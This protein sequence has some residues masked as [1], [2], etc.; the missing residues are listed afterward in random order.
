DSVRDRERD[1]G[2]DERDGRAERLEEVEA[3]PAAERFFEDRHE[4]GDREQIGGPRTEPGRIPELGDAL[5]TTGAGDDAYLE[6]RD[7]VRGEERHDADDQSPP[8]R[9]WSAKGEGLAKRKPPRDQQD[10]DEQDGVDRD[11]GDRRALGRVTRAGI[12]QP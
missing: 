12:V 11:G 9:G 8:P 2:D 6:E 5:L 10:D 1:R 4:D 7:G 3:Q